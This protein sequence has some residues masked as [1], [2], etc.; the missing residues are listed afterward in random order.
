MLCVYSTVDA[1]G[2]PSTLEETMY[3]VPK[4]FIMAG[5]SLQVFAHWSQRGM[6]KDSVFQWKFQNDLPELW[7]VNYVSLFRLFGGPEQATHCLWTCSRT[8]IFKDKVSGWRSGNNS[9]DSFLSKH[10]SII[11]KNINTVLKCSVYESIYSKN[12]SQMSQKVLLMI[13]VKYLYEKKIQ[14]IIHVSLVLSPE[15]FLLLSITF[16]NYSSPKSVPNIFKGISNS[17]DSTD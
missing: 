5:E 17:T 6:S 12:K 11:W 7:S 2:E 13:V 15:T 1:G 8:F 9:M 10:S 16:L 3:K 4:A 14:I